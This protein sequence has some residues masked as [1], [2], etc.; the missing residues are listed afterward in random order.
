MSETLV[1]PHQRKGT[2]G[3]RRHKRITVRLMPREEEDIIRGVE[4]DEHSVIT[5]MTNS[6]HPGVIYLR[7]PRLVG[8]SFVEEVTPHTLSHETIHDTLDQLGERDAS[9]ALD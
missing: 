7:Q 5:G 1:R 8:E 9:T 2:R 6:E 4:M 3:V